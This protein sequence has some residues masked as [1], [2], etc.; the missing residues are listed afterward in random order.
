MSMVLSCLYHCQATRETTHRRSIKNSLGCSNPL[1]STSPQG[2]KL[3][4]LWGVV[5]SKLMQHTINPRL[6][7]TVKLTGLFLVQWLT[8]AQGTVTCWPH[9]LALPSPSPSLPL[10]LQLSKFVLQVLVFGFILAF[11]LFF[12][13]FLNP[14]LLLWLMAYVASPILT[15]CFC[16]SVFES[17]LAMF[18]SLLLGF[19][20]RRVESKW[21]ISILAIGT[22]G[23]S[24]SC[25]R[26]IYLSCLGE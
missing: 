15:L 12:F 5:I 7:F 13:F 19:I 6:L 10:L 17:P 1:V 8:P 11:C 16:L 23:G 14:K 20:L 22:F 26:P 25:A 21:I 4:C 18:L 2:L 24:A 9:A 3:K